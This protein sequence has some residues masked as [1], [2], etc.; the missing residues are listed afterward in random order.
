MSELYQAIVDMDEEKAIALA[1][2]QL[3]DGVDPVT[4]LDDCRDAL[5]TVGKLFEEGKY[6]VPELVLAGDIMAAISA[7]ARPLINKKDNPPNAVKSSSAPSKAISTM[8][9]K[10][11]SR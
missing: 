8:W 6:Y 5:T 10:T 1:K 7:E 11:S 4:V 2:K 9:V 3:A